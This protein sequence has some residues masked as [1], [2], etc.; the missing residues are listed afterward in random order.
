MLSVT[1][2]VTEVLSLKRCHRCCVIDGMCQSLVTLHDENSS[3]CFL[4]I[5]CI[6]S[7]IFIALYNESYLVAGSACDNYTGY[8]DEQQ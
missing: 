7:M 4:F 6:S 1:R 8:C 3:K 5:F 2:V